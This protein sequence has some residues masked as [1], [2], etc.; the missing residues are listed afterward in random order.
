MLIPQRLS[1]ETAEFEIY[2]VLTNYLKPLEKYLFPSCR[3]KRAKNYIILEDQYLKNKAEKLECLIS[4]FFFQNCE[5]VNLVRDL[6]RIA[7]F[8]EIVQL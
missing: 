3:T 4:I 8:K 5:S 2:G 6:T 1:P 7:S